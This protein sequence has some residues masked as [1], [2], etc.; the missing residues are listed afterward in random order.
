[1]NRAT[2]IIELPLLTVD[3]LKANGVLYKRSRKIES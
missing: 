3:P 2:K 1:M